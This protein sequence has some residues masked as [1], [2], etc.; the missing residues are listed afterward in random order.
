[1]PALSMVREAAAPHNV[2][3]NV[4]VIGGS[5]TA[6]C[7]VIQVAVSALSACRN[8]ARDAERTPAAS[9]PAAA[10]SPQ[11]TKRSPRYGAPATPC[12]RRVRRC[13]K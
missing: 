6:V 8:G 5:T 2:Y 3:D 7:R 4:D 10:R 13:M 9:Y 12:A 1:M 11:E